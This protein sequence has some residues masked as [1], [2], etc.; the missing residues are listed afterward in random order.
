MR[1]SS[2]LL[3]CAFLAGCAHEEEAPSKP[4]VAVK[5]VRAE[6]ADLKVT[7]RAPATLFPR[8]QANISA[9]VTAPIREL[10]SRKGDVVKAGQVLAL[11]ENRDVLAQRQEAH[12]SVLDAEANLQK[13]SAGT[14]PTDIERARGQ[15]MLAEASLNQAQK[16]YERRAELYR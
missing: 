16:Y 10:R 13:L 4:V 11:L 3:L 2:V 9:R 8:E 15:V 7:V 12:A 5:V 1:Y 6:T 14:L